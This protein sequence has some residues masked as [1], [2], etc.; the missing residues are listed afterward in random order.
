MLTCKGQ[1]INDC[2]YSQCQCECAKKIVQQNK[3]ISFMK[4]LV[5]KKF[6]DSKVTH[7]WK[8]QGAFR[9]LFDSIERRNDEIFFPENVINVPGGY[10]PTI[11]RRNGP[12]PMHPIV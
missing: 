4:R 9:E 11:A 8:Y 12:T 2:P 7:S 10:V 5:V 1:W 3:I 6:K